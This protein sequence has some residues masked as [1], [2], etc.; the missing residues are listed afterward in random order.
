MEIRKLNDNDY[1]DILVNWWKDWG[2]TPPQKDF[3]PE[4]GAGGFI[5]YDEDTPICAGFIYITNSKVAWIEWIVSN[6]QYR[7]K[8]NRKNALDLLIHTLTS[9]CKDINLKYIFSNNNNNNL[10]NNFINN[11]YIKGCTNSTE[12]IKI[13]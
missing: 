5:V 12:L 2:W 9:Y 6:K 3:L 4:N 10:I 8:P 11:G 13:L 1:D 7:E